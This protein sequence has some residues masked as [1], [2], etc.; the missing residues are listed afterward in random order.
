MISGI[1]HQLKYF[2]QKDGVFKTHSFDIQFRDK[3]CGIEIVHDG[4]NQKI[5]VYGGRYLAICELKNERISLIGKCKLTN[6]ISSVRPNALNW[7]DIDVVTTY[8]VAVKLRM[9][10][11]EGVLEI[12]RKS[13]CVERSTLYCSHIRSADAQDGW[14]SLRIFGGTA[15][16]EVL[17]WSPNE[18]GRSEILYR[19]STPMVRF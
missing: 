16:G 2:Y 14:T 15:L 19:F 4:T 8:N 17:I 12:I 3:I 11:S 7:T 6:V 5:C 9:N 18:S 13:V 10:I 1:G